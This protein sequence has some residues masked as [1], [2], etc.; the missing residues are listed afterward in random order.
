MEDFAWRASGIKRLIVAKIDLSQ[1]E[2]SGLKFKHFPALVVYSPGKKH[3]PE[4]YEGDRS[5]D[6]FTKYFKG[7]MGNHFEVETEDL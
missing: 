5:V 4:D 7:K 1:N 3:S 6:G 2:V